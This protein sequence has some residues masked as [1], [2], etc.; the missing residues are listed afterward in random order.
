MKKQF[1]S[2]LDVN[3]SNYNTSKFERGRRMNLIKGETGTCKEAK[4]II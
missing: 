3:I 1:L 4:W 2:T